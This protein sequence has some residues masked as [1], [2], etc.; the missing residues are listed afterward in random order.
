MNLNST[1][2]DLAEHPLGA[3]FIAGIRK[4]SQSRVDLEGLTDIEK[5]AAI[6]Q[7]KMSEASMME[8][9]LKKVITLSG[10]RISESMI[11]DL[12]HHINENKAY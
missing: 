10:G 8:M 1:I 5:E 2:G 6:K 7:Q 9:P 11:L 3:E 4:M 12:I